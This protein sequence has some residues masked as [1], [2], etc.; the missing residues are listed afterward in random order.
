MD[1]QQRLTLESMAAVLLGVQ[2]KSASR[3]TWRPC[4][5]F[6]GISSLDYVRLTDRPGSS[7]T[8]FDATGALH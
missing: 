2:G 1:P 6:V 3:L 8:A 5:V 7:S 4:G